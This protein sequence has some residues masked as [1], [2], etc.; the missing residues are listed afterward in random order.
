[1][2]HDDAK[3]DPAKKGE[4]APSPLLSPP[5]PPAAHSPTFDP[6]RV[7][8]LARKELREILRDR[9]TII[10]LIAMPLLLYPL[11]SVAFQQFALASRVT[12]MAPEY[13]MGALTGAEVSIFDW[14]FTAGQAAWLREQKLP[15]DKALA[16]NRSRK[17]TMQWEGPGFNPRSDQE[18]A[19]GLELLKEKLRAGTLDLIVVIPKIGEHEGAQRPPARDRLLDCTIYAMPNSPI[20]RQALANIDGAFAALNEENL[21]K[22]LGLPQAKPQILL[23]DVDRIFLESTANDG[24]ISLAALVPLVLILMTITGAVYP[25][26]DLTAGEHERGTLEILVA[27]PVPRFEL[28]SAKYITVVTVAVLNAIV[29]L[30]CMSATVAWSGLGP[31]LV[32][33]GLTFVLIVE[34]FGLL[35]LF[36]G[37]FSA[38]L[39]C[40]TSLARSFKEAQAYLIPLMLASLT[41][42]IMA[43][44]PGLKLTGILKVLPLVNIVLLARDLFDTGSDVVTAMMVILTTILYAVAALSLAAR[45]FGGESVLYNEQSSWSDLLRRPDAPQPAATI[46]AAL[47]CLALMVPIQFG[48]IALLRVLAPS[49]AVIVGLIIAINVLLF[50]LL[51]A[52]F[53]YLGRVQLVSGLN[54]ALPRPAAWGAGIVF[55]VSV[56]PL[57]LWLLAHRDRPEG[58]E[59]RLGGLLDNLKNVR[60]TIGW[61]VLAV[62]IVPAILEEFFFR[63]MLFSALKARCNAVLTIA[64]SGLLFGLSHMV[65]DGALGLERLLPALLLGLILGAV[66]WRTGSLW[67]GMLQ[68]V[69]HNTALLT[70]GLTAPGSVTEIPALWLAGSAVGIAIGAFLLWQ[71]GGGAVNSPTQLAEK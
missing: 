54:L 17:P 47:W 49:P 23:L 57:Q 16:W 42:G 52:Y 59:Q 68:H 10:T 41:P 39:L 33:G 65:L 48:L 31:V 7:L 18:R 40:L 29:N 63:G 44:M 2:G 24:F 8:R 62:V 71:W 28:L 34:V 67:P 36:A 5:H 27:T 58:L 46:P 6:R 35:F 4:P 37:F 45:V 9:R 69:C 12:N 60:E 11:M 30:I 21:K 15:A 38:V 19:A 61:W 64:L 20:A 55:G 43:M 70:V 1:M 22:R 13:H 50:G 25:A 66:C 53:L 56:W 26:I 51:P 14:H 3:D 32:E